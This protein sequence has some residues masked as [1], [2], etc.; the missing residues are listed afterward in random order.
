MRMAGLLLLTATLWGQAT[1]RTTTQ[2]VVETVT[3]KDKSGRP[4]TGLTAKD[5]V[6]TE[7]GM[8]QEIKFFEFQRLAEAVVAPAVEALARLTRGD[9]AGGDV[10]YRD[11]R[12]L[13]FYFDLTAMPGPDQIRAFRATKIFR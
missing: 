9:I 8:A 10:R 4:M 13:A 5:F 2:L 7:D 6:L 11:K 3:V 12:L 1:F